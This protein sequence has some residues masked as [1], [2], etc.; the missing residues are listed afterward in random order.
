M[1]K[2]L[3]VS[4]L[5]M[6]AVST[7]RA[8]IASTKYVDDQIDGLDDV[9]ADAVENSAM[10]TQS[11]TQEDGTVTVAVTE[12]ASSVTADN[13]V[14][15]TSAAVYAA[16]NPIKIIVEDKPWEDGNFVANDTVTS[17]KIAD[18]EV[19]TVDIADLAVTTE[20]IAN[21]AVT[22]EKILDGEVETVDIADLAV[23]TEKIADDAVTS[24]K[25]ADGAIT[26]V[27]G[28]VP[29]DVG[30]KIVETDASRLRQ[31]DLEDTKKYMSAPTVVSYVDQ[32]IGGLSN[33]VGNQI[34][35]KQPK[36]TLDFQVGGTQGTWFN[37]V[38]T[39]PA[40]CTVAKAECALVSAADASGKVTVKWSVVVE[41]DATSSTVAVV[42]PADEDRI[43]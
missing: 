39:L 19:K 43:K 34:A 3:S 18:G 22:S 20:K 4:L 7:A 25:I 6:L 35:G 14:A 28:Y 36:S 21:N 10:Y 5:A 37:L 27:L 30:N 24:A 23:T 13:N 11:V 9:S 8:D 32:E 33:T 15:P 41:G 42:A 40:A 17:E 2:I 26:D 38:D 16:I 12:F 1:K 31:A 29:E